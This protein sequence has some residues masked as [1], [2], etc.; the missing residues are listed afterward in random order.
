VIINGEIVRDSKTVLD[1]CEDAELAIGV[2]VAG[3]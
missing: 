2:M 3:G 1:F